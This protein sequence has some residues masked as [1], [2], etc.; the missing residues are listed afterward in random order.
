MKN[1]Y[2]GPTENK[3]ETQTLFRG[4]RLFCRRQKLRMDGQVRT[5]K[6]RFEI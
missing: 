3:P 4:F 6:N 1:R 2:L 5:P